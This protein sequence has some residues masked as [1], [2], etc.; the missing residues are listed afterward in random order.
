MSCGCNSV[1]TFG[2]LNV[3]ITGTTATINL[4]GALPVSGR[5]NVRICGSCLDVCSGDTVVI[6]DAA[7]TTLS[8]VLDKCGNAVRLNKVAVQA[9]KHRCLHFC[10]SVGTNIA[11]LQDCI[12]APTPVID[13]TAA[14][15][16]AAARA[17]RG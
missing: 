16:A 8:T 4:D 13:N 12:C 7:G 10:R 15:A 11:V 3:T 9:R 14:A 1:P 17:A 5:F 2:V 6:V